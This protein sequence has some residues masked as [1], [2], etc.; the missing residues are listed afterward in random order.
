MKLDDTSRKLLRILYN[1]RG[2]PLI[3]ELARMSV[4]TP[5]QVKMAL[6]VLA[7]EG[8]IQYDPDNHRELKIIQAWEVGPEVIDVRALERR[9]VDWELYPGR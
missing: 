2:V 3:E 5:G 9:M 8:F 1:A 6:R 7:V 4:R